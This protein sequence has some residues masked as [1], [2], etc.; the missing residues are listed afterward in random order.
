MPGMRIGSYTLDN[1]WILAPMAGVSE[2]PFRVIARR[3]GASAAPTELV[4]CKGLVYGQTR[5]ARYLT[6]DP[7][8]QP[9]WVQ[10][11]GGDPESMARGALCAAELGAAIID[12]NMGCPV[13]KVTKTGA[14]C[15]LMQDPDRA[16]RIVEAITASTGLPV[17]AK[18]RSGWDAHS[19]N[20]IEVTR[21]LADAG[22]CAVAVHARTRSQG[23]SGAADWGLIARLAE[24]SPIP[25]IG[26]GGV[27]SA[28]DGHALLERTGCAAVMV[29]RG[30]LGNPW[31]FTQLVD[32]HATPPAP[33]QR[34]A[35][36]REHLAA[37]LAF[38]GDELRAI[39]RFRQHVM[40][41]AHGLRGATAFRRTVVHL[42]TASDVTA[43][44]E[45]FFSSAEQSGDAPRARHVDV[46]AALG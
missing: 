22:C 10:L 27:F 44:C 2:M 45:A 30:A 18:I 25:V 40:W 21:R 6:H 16:A 15:A 23:Y 42:E 31:I 9:F 24:T 36:V 46:R 33:E 37:H 38:V 41:Y 28:A 26:N 4:S 32:P 3:L 5:T 8:E 14:G 11:F 20:A 35:M 17:T 1:P 39:R 7:S 34:W 19:V 13:R 12:V 43:A 29:G